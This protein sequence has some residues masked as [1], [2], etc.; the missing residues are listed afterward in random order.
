MNPP[1]PS[2][3]SSINAV[4]QKLN[5]DLGRV[6]TGLSI[7]IIFVLLPIAAWNYWEVLP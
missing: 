3:R 6:A 2:R 4:M 5:D 1:P 7:L